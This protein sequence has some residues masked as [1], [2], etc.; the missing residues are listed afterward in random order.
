MVRP[1]KWQCRQYRARSRTEKRKVTIG[2]V[3]FTSLCTGL[4]AP[5][6]Y[7]ILLHFQCVILLGHIRVLTK[8]SLKRDDSGPSLPSLHIRIVVK[9][10]GKEENYKYYF[11][12][13][14]RIELKCGKLSNP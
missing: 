2:L 11:F 5:R 8:W 9:L 6:R 3:S 4:L 14:E 1:W 12:H 7:C 13:R 10:K